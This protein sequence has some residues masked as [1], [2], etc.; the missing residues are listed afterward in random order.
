MANPAPA[1]SCSDSRRAA[2]GPCRHWRAHFIETLAISSSVARAAEAAGVTPARA[3]HTRRTEPDFARAWREAMS[4]NEAADFLQDRAGTLLD[5]KVSAA[6]QKVVRGRRT[7]TF[8]SPID[9]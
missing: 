2:P 3:Y 1:R 5:P 4:P 9:A 7:L 8:I 6:L